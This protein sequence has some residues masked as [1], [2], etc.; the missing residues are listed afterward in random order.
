MLSAEALAVFKLLFFRPKD[1]VDIEKLLAI[2]G[3][4][5]DKGYVR[6]Q[7]AQ[8]LG[9]DDARIREWDRLTST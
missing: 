3:A 9:E 4:R 5:F 8:I 2:R 1:L 7:L 6:D